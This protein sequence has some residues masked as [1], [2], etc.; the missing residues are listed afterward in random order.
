[1]R[2]KNSVRGAGDIHPGMRLY[3]LDKRCDDLRGHWSGFSRGRRAMCHPRRKDSHIHITTMQAGAHRK[4][5]DSGTYADLVVKIVDHLVG[6]GV[7]E[8]ATGWPDHEMVFKAGIGHYRRKPVDA[9]AAFKCG[10]IERLFKRQHA[11]LLFK[12]RVEDDSSARCLRKPHTGSMTGIGAKEETGNRQ[13]Q[14]QRHSGQVKP[15]PPIKSCIEIENHFGLH[16]VIRGVI[17]GVFR[18]DRAPS[19]SDS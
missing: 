19:R 6:D 15:A 5:T 1:M 8:N 4:V 14:K 9:R 2:V 17:L 18:P 12:R 3:R 13:H 11:G 16:P 10:E 7:I